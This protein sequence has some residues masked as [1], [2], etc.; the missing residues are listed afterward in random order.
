MSVVIDWLEESKKFDEVSEIYDLYRPSY[1]EALV[2]KIIEKSKVDTTSRCLEIGA[3]SGKATELFANKDLNIHCIEQG[4]NLVD[5]G[6]AKFID[7]DKVKFECVAFQDWEVEE[8]TFDLAFSAQAFH[9]VPKPQG[10]KTLAKA[11]KDHGQMMIFWNKYI[12]NESDVSNQLASI[13]KEYKIMTM[14]NNKELDTFKNRTYDGIYTT[15]LFVDI[16]VHTYPWKQEYT[17]NEFVNFLKTT[18]RYI[19]LDKQ[20]QHVVNVRLM[21]LF[22]DNDYKITIDFE[23]VL[24]SGKKR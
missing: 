4:E 18:N 11:L 1:P 13:L 8:D 3:G 22:S 14:L 7:N 5:K 9:W 2:N 17:Y 20:E 6:K 15:D 21:E 23:A 10:Y 24:F 12:N 19:G 16:E